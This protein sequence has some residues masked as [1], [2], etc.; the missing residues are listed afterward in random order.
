M[1]VVPVVTPVTM[2]EVV[3][4][5]ATPVELL[6]QA[7]PVVASAKAIL[8]PTQTADGP[9]MAGGVGLITTVELPLIALSQPALVVATMV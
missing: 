2:P 5:T 8:A 1:I 7:P 3:P 6:L 9:P 4:I